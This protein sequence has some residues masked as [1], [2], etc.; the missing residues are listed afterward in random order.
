MHF[1]IQFKTNKSHYLN[2]R[3]NHNIYILMKQM[4]DGIYNINLL[5]ITDHLI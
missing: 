5:H 3:Y 1:I 2:R 4:I